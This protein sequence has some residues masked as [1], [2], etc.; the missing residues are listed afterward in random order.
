MNAP[1]HLGRWLAAAV[2]VLIAPV[3]IHHPVEVVWAI[4]ALLLA[5]TAWHITFGSRRPLVRKGKD[6]TLRH[7]PW[8]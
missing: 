2:V 4:A 7:P 8:T 5:L 6:R 3:F 1:K